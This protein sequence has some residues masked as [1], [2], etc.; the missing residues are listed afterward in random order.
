[1]PWWIMIVGLM[2]AVGVLSISGIQVRA[3]QEER[4]KPIVM[5]EEQRVIEEADEDEKLVTT[6]EKKEVDY[7]LSYPGILPDH[8]LYWLK[9]I[10]DRVQLLLITNPLAKAEKLLLYAD[11][12]LGASWALIEGNKVDLGVTTLTKAEKYLERAILA[13]KQLGDG[14]KEKQFKEKL[15][16][17]E[18][19]HREVLLD[20]KGGMSEDYKGIIEKILIVGR[21]R[22][23]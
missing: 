20:L 11:K 7:Y 1:M 2:F 8:P 12:R 3:Q 9:M 13:G 22:L 16:K 18:M 21:I 17:A 6:D 4:V 14:E 5:E 10:R 23:D 19:K 15:N